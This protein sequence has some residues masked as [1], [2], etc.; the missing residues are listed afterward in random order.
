MKKH[1]LLLTGLFIIT[2]SGLFAQR[3]TIAAWTFPTGI[4]T[5]DFY[6][7]AG[8]ASNSKNAISAEDTTAWPNTVVRDLR[9][10]TGVSDYACGATGQTLAG[11]PER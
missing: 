1:L 10:S 2:A 5:V 8:L 11:P 3:D 9:L 7:N 6:P 4:D